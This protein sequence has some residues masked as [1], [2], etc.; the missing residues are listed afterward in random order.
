MADPSPTKTESEFE[1]GWADGTGRHPLDAL[2]RRHGW[3]VARRPEG[4]APLWQKGKLLLPEANALATL[5]EKEVDAARKAQDRYYGRRLR[6][7]EPL[8]EAA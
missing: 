1:H 4:E 6:D 5:P 3:K 2:L 8:N 7:A